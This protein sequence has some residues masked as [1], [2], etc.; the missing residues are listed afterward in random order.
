[1]ISIVASH[2]LRSCKTNHLLCFGTEPFVQHTGPVCNVI[3]VPKMGC[4]APLQDQRSYTLMPDSSII[5]YLISPVWCL[6]LSHSLIVSE[7]MSLPFSGTVSLGSRQ[8]EDGDT[9]D[10]LCHLAVMQQSGAHT[11]QA[12]WSQ[13]LLHP[14]GLEGR[15]TAPSCF[16]RTRGGAGALRGLCRCYLPGYLCRN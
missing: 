15:C 9:K 6:F 5:L 11:K 12:A 14:A 4:E 10:L 7:K 8:C 1:M 3:C 16:Q 2:Y 13:T